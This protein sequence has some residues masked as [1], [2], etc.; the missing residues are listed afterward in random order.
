[1]GEVLLFIFT[2]IFI[3]MLY[4]VFTIRKELNKINGKRKNKWKFKSKIFKKLKLSKKKTD[5]MKLPVEINYLVFRYKLDLKKIV[6]ARLLQ[7]VAFVTSLDL[8]IVI[9]IVSLIN[10]TGPQLLIG[11]IILVPVIVISYHF[12]GLYYRKKGMIINV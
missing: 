12:I 7:V 5:D 10:G 9:T 11:F 6:Y 8:S 1:M 2:F 3:Y 4:Y